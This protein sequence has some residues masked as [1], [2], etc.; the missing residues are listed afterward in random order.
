MRL[1]GRKR[2]LRYLNP[3]AANLA[4]HLLAIANHP[5]ICLPLSVSTW[6]LIVKVCLSSGEFP[7]VHD[8]LISPLEFRML[9]R[10]TNTVAIPVTLA[11][12]FTAVDHVFSDGTSVKYV[13]STVVVFSPAV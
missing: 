12:S 5:H 13:M 9:V 4:A 2:A 8:L 6:L 11:F 3:P 10:T 7:S 1:L